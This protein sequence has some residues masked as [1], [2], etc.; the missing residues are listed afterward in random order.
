MAER[1]W[2]VAVSLGLVLGM[3]A[4]LLAREAHCARHAV[5][6]AFRLGF[7]DIKVVPWINTMDRCYSQE[8]V[9]F[10]VVSGTTLHGNCKNSILAI[11]TT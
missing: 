4:S 7:C 3:T 8:T 11:M 9:S 5:C 10:H 2:M 1:S 6:E